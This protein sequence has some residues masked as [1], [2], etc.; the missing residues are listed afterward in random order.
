MPPDVSALSVLPDDEVFPL[1]PS[2][3]DCVLSE[4]FPDLCFVPE[5]ELGGYKICGE[6]WTCNEGPIEGPWSVTI[7]VSMLE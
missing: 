5:E 1:F 2:V 3:V 7:P 4:S 6:F